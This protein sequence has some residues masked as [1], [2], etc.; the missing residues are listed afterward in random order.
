MWSRTSYA[1]ILR[2][3]HYL[4]G[5][6]LLHVPVA[7]FEYKPLG[8]VGLNMP[9]GNNGGKEEY[10][11]PGIEPR[12]CNSCVRLEQ[13]TGTGQRRRIAGRPAEPTKQLRAET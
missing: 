12:L 10:L 4:T 1:H 13:E 7:L 5:T 2:H 3:R 8:S 11:V 6:G 9:S